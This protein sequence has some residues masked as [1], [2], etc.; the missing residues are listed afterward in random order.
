MITFQRNFQIVLSYLEKYDEKSDSIRLHQA[1][2]SQIGVFLKER[3]I[4]YSHENALEWLREQSGPKAL[5]GTFATAVARIND[6]YQSG[7][8]RFQ[9]RVRKQLCPAFESIIEEYLKDVSEQYSKKH[10]P[11]IRTRCRFLLFFKEAL[12]VPA[13]MEQD[14]PLLFSGTE[15]EGGKGRVNRR[16]VPFCHN[17]V[18]SVP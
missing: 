2:Y 12:R 13:G 6:V 15:K 14:P 16:H 11:N 4:L 5:M 3:S 10:L 9:H 8:V 1:C 17:E 7:H 18:L